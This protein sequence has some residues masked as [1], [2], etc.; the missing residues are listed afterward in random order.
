[1]FPVFDN[2]QPHDA[3]EFFRVWHAELARTPGTTEPSP[4][5]ARWLAERDVHTVTYTTCAHCNR[6]VH[7][8]PEG[9]KPPRDPERVLMASLRPGPAYS[10][11][12]E[13]LAGTFGAIPVLDRYCDPA[14][15]GCGKTGAHKSTKCRTLPRVLVVCLG[16][17]GIHAPGLYQRVD[18]PVERI[19]ED[20]DLTGHLDALAASAGGDSAA[21]GHR[22]TVPTGTRYRTRAVVCYDCRKLHYTC[23]VRAAPDSARR[24]RD[25]W[26]NYDDSIVGP[27]Q[28]TLPPKVATEAYVVFYELMPR[29]QETAP[30]PISVPADQQASAEPSNED[31]RES[32][33]PLAPA[34]L[35]WY[36]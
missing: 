36:L 25:S 29:T 2:T 14:S 15:G 31:S 6:T 16:R 34:H 11:V 9:N 7:D 30:E 17:Y 5:W 26:V 12:M 33:A 32:P 21:A 18:T 4:A 35:P 10:G 1:M 19:E 20:I 13:A 23:W 24:T 22:T 27:P 3:M 28:P 8:Q